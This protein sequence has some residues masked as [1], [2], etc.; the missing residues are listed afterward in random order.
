MTV[1]KG[2]SHLCRVPVKGGAKSAHL[3]LISFETAEMITKGLKRASCYK[4]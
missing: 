3:L 1:I 4:E 2:I